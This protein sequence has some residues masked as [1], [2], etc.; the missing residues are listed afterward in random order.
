M[1]L[2]ARPVRMLTAAAA[3]AAQAQLP[4]TV[5]Q[6]P[7]EPTTQPLALVVQ[8]GAEAVVVEVALA[9]L[10]ALVVPADFLAVEVAGVVLVLAQAA[11]AA[12]VALVTPASP[13]GKEYD[14]ALRNH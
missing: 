4:V 5:H 13:L 2:E 12:L 9:L 8:V 11:Q 10:V 1:L 3:L 7:Q 14:H 6:E